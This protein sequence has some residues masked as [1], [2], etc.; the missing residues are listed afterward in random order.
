MS[1][2]VPSVVFKTRVRNEELG[3]PNPFEWKDVSSDDLFKGKNVVVFSLPGAFTPTC[4]TSH[5]PRFEELYSEFTAQGID[6]VICIS[7]NDA[8]VMYQ[9][10]KSQNAQNVFLLPDGNGDFTRQMGMLVKKD[11]LGFGMRSWRYAM[12]VENGNIVKM[13]S[14]AG[15]QDNA[16]AD[17]FEVSDADTMLNYLKSRA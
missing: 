17:P 13:F 2:T 11:N 4:S 16:P 5:L 14:E 1:N 8:F 10:G 12:H 6:A 3:G 15:Y 9:W 7:V